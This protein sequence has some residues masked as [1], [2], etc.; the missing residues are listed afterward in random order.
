MAPLVKHLMCKDEIWVWT[1]ASLPLSIMAQYLQSQ[2]WWGGTKVPVAHWADQQ[3]RCSTNLVSTKYPASENAQWPLIWNIL[4]IG[5]YTGKHM[6]ANIVLSNKAILCHICGWSHGSLHVYSLVGG[7]VPRSSRG[8]AIWLCC[9]GPPWTPMDPE[10]SP[11]VGCKHHLCICEAL[12]EPLRKQL[13]QA[14]VSKHFPAS[15]IA[16]GFD[17]YI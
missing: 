14:P 10:L 1:S 16:S 13:Y 2:F 9:H 5:W 17:Y 12:E 6:V 7:P 11:M 4:I 8:L 15:A 3:A